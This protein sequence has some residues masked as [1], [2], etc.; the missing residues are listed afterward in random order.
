MEKI[1][2]F[3]KKFAVDHFAH[4]VVP[5]LMHFFSRLK[6]PYSCFY[7]NFCLLVIFVLLILVLSVL[8]RVAV[9]IIMS[10]W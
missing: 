10:C 8:F 1:N 5:S 2:K 3:F 4:S 6:C 7:S 9:I